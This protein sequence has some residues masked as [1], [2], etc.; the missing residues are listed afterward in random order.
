MN[1]GGAG[2]EGDI[3]AIVDKEPGATRRDGVWG[4][5][6]GAVRRRGAASSAPT[7]EFE[8][9]AAGEIFLAQLNRV[10]AGA[11]CAFDRLEQTGGGL[12]IFEAEGTAI[13]DV[14]HQRS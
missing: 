10:H 1:S 6:A 7:C 2:S 12:G 9:G 14:E 8:Q 11:S 3:Q 13:G 4:T 5:R